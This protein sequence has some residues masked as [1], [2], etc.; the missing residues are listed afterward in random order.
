MNEAYVEQLIRRKSPAGFNAIRILMIVLAVFS[1]AVGI[2]VSPLG[3]LTAIAAGGVAVVLQ[4]NAEI[5][6]EY[7]FVDRELTVDI[8]RNKA[9]R[10]K[11]GTVEVNHMELFAPAGSD[12]LKAYLDKGLKVRDYSSQMEDSDPYAIVYNGKKGMEI[13][14]VEGSEELYKCFFTTAPRKVFKD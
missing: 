11:V 12:R 6:Y 8:I 3:F 10:K 13:M 5:E 2:L 9:R 1:V 4:S 14:L 7:L